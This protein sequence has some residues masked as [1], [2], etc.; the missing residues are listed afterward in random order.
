MFVGKYATRR[1]ASLPEE[2]LRD[3]NAYLWGITS[4][5]GSG[6]YCISESRRDLH[7]R[8]TDCPEAHLLAPGAFARRPIVDRISALK[9]PVTFVCE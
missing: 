6:E 7:Q 5:K 9:V 1:F 3:M 8:S 4:A 2:E